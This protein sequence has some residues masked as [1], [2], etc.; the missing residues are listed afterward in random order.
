MIEASGQS[1]GLTEVAAEFDDED[2][3]VDSSDLFKEAVGAVA[4]AVVNKDELEGFANLLHNGLETV[5]ERSDAL[6]FV[7][8]RNYDG[9]L[10]HS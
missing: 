1:G 4:G 6:L 10:W 8:E 9:I 5:V 3:A 7:M 2:A